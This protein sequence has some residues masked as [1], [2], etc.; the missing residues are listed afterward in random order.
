MSKR[1][2]LSW[3]SGNL[4]TLSVE[5]IIT[6]LCIALL[7]SAVIFFTYKLTYSGVSYN[8]RFNSGN[9]IITLITAVIMMMIGSNI[10]ISL[11]MVGALSI[12]RFRTAIKDP[13]DTIYVFWSLVTG[14]CVGA[15][16]YQ[17]AVISSVFIAIVVV[18]LSFYS[19]LNSKYIVIIRGDLNVDKMVIDKALKE[20]FKSVR[21][22]S[23]NNRENSVEMIFEV[24]A[25]IKGLDMSKVDALK[26][27]DGV[28][29]A[30]YILEA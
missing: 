26:N 28:K 3:F 12:V 7:L 23:V 29:S 14:L 9:V 2:I 18:A 4:S 27:V 13:Q 8:A 15:Q 20:S 24:C 25:A 5:K 22:R 19:S 30:N 17:L 6:V 10:A 11:G 16:V 1:E 21:V